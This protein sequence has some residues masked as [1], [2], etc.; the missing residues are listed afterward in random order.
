MLIICTGEKKRCHNDSPH[1]TILSERVV[2]KALEDVCCHCHVDLYTISFYVSEFTQ[3]LAQ[4]WEQCCRK[5]DAKDANR[6]SWQPCSWINP[7]FTYILS[8]CYQDSYPMLSHIVTFYVALFIDIIPDMH[9]IVTS[10]R[11][12]FYYSIF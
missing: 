8:F 2:A 1:Q 10:V 11:G 5:S 9:N 6:E 7:T 3:M 12:A 4:K